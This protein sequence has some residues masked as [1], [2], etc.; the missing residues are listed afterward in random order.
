MSLV[1]IL[2]ALCLSMTIAI[3]PIAAPQVH[4]HQGHGVTV[5][6][7]ETAP[8][9]HTA[10]VAHMHDH[11]GPATAEHHGKKQGSDQS[12]SC[13]GTVACHAFL[14]SMTPELLVSRSSVRVVAFYIE[15]QT[16]GHFPGGLDRPPRPA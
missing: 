9:S 11:A 15:E 6:A 8:H 13:C 5:Q 16:S 12:P 3:F 10:G 4:A 14:A 2:W 1:R 7:E